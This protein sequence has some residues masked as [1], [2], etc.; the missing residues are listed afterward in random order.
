MH[1]RR[2]YL[3]NYV[4]DCYESET[5]S[6]L[7]ILQL[8]VHCLKY[9]C[10]FPRLL[11]QKPAETCC[12]SSDRMHLLFKYLSRPLAPRAA[13][14]SKISHSESASTFLTSPLSQ[15]HTHKAAE[16]PR[17]SQQIFLSQ[18]DVEQSAACVRPTSCVCMLCNADTLSGFP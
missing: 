18:A 16:Q 13:P 4:C 8:I 10:V 14:G 1:R 11:L 12:S 15:H 2:Q 17:V 6:L 7:F 9:V 5:V 3:L